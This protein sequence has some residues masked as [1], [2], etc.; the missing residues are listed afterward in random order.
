[1]KITYKDACNLV[2]GIEQVNIHLAIICEQPGAHPMLKQLLQENQSAAV[3]AK[4]I[5]D[6][7][8]L[9]LESELRAPT[10]GLRPLYLGESPRQG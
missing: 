7:G 5:R 2:A 1:M 8:G 4:N 10:L 6:N 3:V 9:P